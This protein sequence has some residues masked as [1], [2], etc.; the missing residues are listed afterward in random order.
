M[1]S[2][3]LM[4]EIA[5]MAHHLPNSGRYEPLTNLSGRAMWSRFISVASQYPEAVASMIS[6]S[7]HGNVITAA[8]DWAAPPVGRR[9]GRETLPDPPID[10]FPPLRTAGWSCLLAVTAEAAEGV[11]IGADRVRVRVGACRG[12]ARNPEAESDG[13]ADEYFGDHFV[14]LSRHVILSSR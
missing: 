7:R 9:P 5:F 13:S 8:V 3:P 4:Y 2:S 11:R 6:S 14:V 12:C 10:L 1:C